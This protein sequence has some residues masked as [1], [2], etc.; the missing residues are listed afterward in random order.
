[1]SELDWSKD[2]KQFRYDKVIEPREDDF[3]DIPS[4]IKVSSDGELIDYYEVY[5]F[6]IEIENKGVLKDRNQI[7]FSFG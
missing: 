6:I 2:G 3:I 4:V 5:Q 1:M 7:V